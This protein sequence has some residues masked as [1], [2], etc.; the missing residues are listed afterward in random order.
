MHVHRHNL[1]L[2]SIICL[3]LSACN[4]GSHYAP[5]TDVSMIEPVPKKTIYRIPPRKTLPDIS[6]RHRWDDRSPSKWIWPAKGKVINAFSSLNKGINIAGKLGDP[7]YAVHDGKVVYS[8]EG[9]RAYGK[10]I[11]IK[12][13][14]LY[15]SAYAHNRHVYVKE[16]DVVK[17]GQ[18]IAEM[19]DTGANKVMLHFEVRCAGKPI[20]PMSLFGGGNDNL[21]I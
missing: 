20:N 7:I 6:W 17:Q 18:K 11:I 15:L 19:G 8:G 2:F 16:G 5:V 3:L 4:E 14:S 10:L 13:N 1:L 12:H 21:G 9:L